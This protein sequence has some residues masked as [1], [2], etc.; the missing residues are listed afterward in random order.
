MEL[1]ENGTN[2]RNRR[3]HDEVQNGTRISINGLLG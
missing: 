1:E 3:I 2:F